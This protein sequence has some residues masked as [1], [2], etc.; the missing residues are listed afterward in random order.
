MVDVQGE[1][2]LE[3]LGEGDVAVLGAFAV[4]DADAAGVQADLGR[5]GSWPRLHSSA[6][7][8]PRGAE[9]VQ[10]REALSYN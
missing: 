4:G 3:G 2:F 5:G 6:T 10:L 9:F 8:A 7:F 1:G